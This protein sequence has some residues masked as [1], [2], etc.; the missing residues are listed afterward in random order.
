MFG[1]RQINHIPIYRPFA[2]WADLLLVLNSGH[3]F[4]NLEFQV[5]YFFC[6]LKKWLSI[7]FFNF[8]G[9]SWCITLCLFQMYSIVPTA[10]LCL[11][12][13]SHPTLCDPWTVA[14]QAPLPKGLFQATILK[15]VAM[16]TSRGIFPTQRPNPGLWHSLPSKPPWKS[17]NTRVGWLSFL[18]GI[19]QTQELKWGFLHCR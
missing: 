17:M 14:C 13:Q 1:K 12:T 16:P 8:F 6:L 19:F 10:V 11:G 3:F 7:L 4:L 2:H 5:F 9:Y 18:Q 15:W